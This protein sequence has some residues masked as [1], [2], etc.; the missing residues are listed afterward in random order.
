MRDGIV[1]VMVGV[2]GLEANV[3][4]DIVAVQQAYASSSR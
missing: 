4:E 2:G 1:F 3:V